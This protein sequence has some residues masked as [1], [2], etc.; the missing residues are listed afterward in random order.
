VTVHVHGSVVQEK[1]LAVTIRD[2]IGV[3]M[4]RQGLNPNILGV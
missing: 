3:L 2:N 1:D 4:R